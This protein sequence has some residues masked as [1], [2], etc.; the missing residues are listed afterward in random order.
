[1][2]A[3]FDDPSL[4]HHQN[5][6]GFFDGGQAMGDDQGG[7]ILLQRIQRFLDCP[8]GF[9]IQRRG[10][11]VEDKYRAI[12]QQRAGDGDTLTLAAGEQD[13]VF[14]DNR[15]QAHV[16][17]FDEIHGVSHA[18]SV[19]YLLAGV[20]CLAG[21]SDIVGDS[22]VKQMHVLGN[23]RHL[24]TQRGELIGA[25]I[26]TVEQDLAL[27]DIVKPR[28]QIGDGRFTGAGSPH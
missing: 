1:M 12:A 18:G 11:L 2:I 19:L 22:I 20:G 21:I 4:L 7:P 5:F 13:A 26:G 8:L 25:Q 27:L 24:I 9:G 15:I 17:F 28:Q 10:G 23:Q 16:H 6:I 3:A 14:A